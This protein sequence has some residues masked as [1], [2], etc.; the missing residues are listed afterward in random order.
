MK[1]R[2]REKAPHRAP[3]CGCGVGGGAGRWPSGG[4]GGGSEAPLGP[5]AWAYCVLLTFQHALSKYSEDM[6]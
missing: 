3:V 1:E 2:G 5:C 6:V 4:R